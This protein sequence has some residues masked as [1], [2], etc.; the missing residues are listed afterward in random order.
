MEGALRCGDGALRDRRTHAAEARGRRDAE[1]LA[2]TRLQADALVTVDP[3]LTA[4][5]AGLVPVAP[6]EALLAQR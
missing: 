6:F 4:K 1:Y 5:A 2:I 3:D